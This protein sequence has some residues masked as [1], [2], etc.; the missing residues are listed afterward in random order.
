MADKE[1]P[2]Q[3]LKRGHG[4]VDGGGLRSIVAGRAA[5]GVRGSALATVARN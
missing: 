5:E 2:Y 1:I 4:D 3:L